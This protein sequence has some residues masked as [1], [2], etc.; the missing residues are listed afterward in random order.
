METLS[1]PSRTQ[2]MQKGL[3]MVTSMEM[4]TS[5]EKMPEIEC[6]LETD[7]SSEYNYFNIKKKWAFKTVDKDSRKI[8]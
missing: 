3:S 4:P 8:H 1:Q 7:T 6:I 5:R 2:P